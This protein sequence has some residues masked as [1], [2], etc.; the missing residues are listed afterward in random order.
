M[1]GFDYSQ[2]AKDKPLRGVRVIEMGQLLAGP[3]CGRIL[4]EFGAEVIKIEAPGKGDPLRVW[5]GMMEETGTSLWWYVQSR[6]KKSVTLDMNLAQAPAL[7]K[8]L[9]ESADVLLEN[10]KPGTMEKW[11]LG[12][13]DVHR[14]Y[15]RLVMTRVS[16]WGQTGPYKDKPGYGSIGESMGGL[17]YL[18]GVPGQPPV[19]TG[20]SIGDSLSGMWAAIGTLMAIYH[21]DARGGAGQLVDVALNEAVFNM[22]EGMLPEFSWLGVIRERTGAAMPGIS[23]SNTYECQDGTYIVIGGNGDS[24]FK[25][26]MR[27]IG[28]PAMADDP[29]FANNNL[30]VKANAEIDSV[31]GEWAA[32]HNY[33]EAIAIL[34]AAGVPA[35]PIYSIADIAADPH[36]QARNMIQE[37]EVPGVGSLKIPGIVPQLS[38]TPGTTEWLG[39]RLGEH[40]REVYGSLLGV[41][42]ATLEE[43]AAAGL[44]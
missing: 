36:F 43:W 5:R 11:G 2:L 20:I 7:V 1:P 19:R 17:R 34:D 27:A 30:R 12:W 13:E 42:E 15:P 10:F 24:I 6:N 23:P 21:R 25:R 35:G 38:E 41:D 44:V 14:L 4:A 8:R 3:F 22:M 28:Q 9:L 40:N 16:G 37:R 32:R 33:A 39:P 29:R 18:T 31:I 26:F